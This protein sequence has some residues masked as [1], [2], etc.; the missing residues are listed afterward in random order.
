[1]T[2]P[3]N[4][5]NQLNMSDRGGLLLSLKARLLTLGYPGHEFLGDL[6]VALQILGATN[7]DS[8]ENVQL[9]H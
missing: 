3:D 6:G 2:N 5:G 7:R 1:M 4:W 9:R 8:F